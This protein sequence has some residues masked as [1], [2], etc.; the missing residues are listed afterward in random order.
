MSIIQPTLTELAQRADFKNLEDRWLAALEENGAHREDMLNALG[1]LTKDGRTERATALGWTWMESAKERLE[2][3]ELLALGRELILQCG[4]NED[5]RQEILR[6]YGEVFADRP[7]LDRLIEASGLRGGKSPRRALRTLEICLGL[8]VGSHLIS[9]IDE[10][11]AEV[12]AIDSEGPEY[13][14]R[15]KGGRT[16]TLDPDSL[17]LNYDPIEA[18]DF[19]VLIQLHPQ[20]LTNMLESDPAGVV[21]GILQ[22]HRGRLD[23]DELEHLLSPRFVPAARWKDWWSKTRAALKRCPNVIVEGRNPVI[24]TYTATAQTLESEIEPQWQRAETPSQRLATIE[25]YVREAKARGTQLQSSLI[26]RMYRDL[27]A[28]VKATRPGAPSEA[29]TEAI[30]IERLIEVSGL[31]GMESPASAILAE[32]KDVVSLIRGM[33][34][35]KLAL[36]AIELIRTTLPEKWQEIYLDLLPFASIDG[37]EFIS[38][39]LSEAGLS[40]R[41]AEVVARIPT[42]FHDHLDAVCWLWRGPSLEIPEPMPPRELLTRLLNFLN[43]LSRD[44]HAD[45]DFVREAKTRIRSAL[46]AA[47]Y[48]RYSEVIA[49]MEPGLAST[50][51]RTVDRMDALGHVV[52]ADLLKIIREVHP[53]LYAKAKVDPWLDETIIYGT[54]AGMNRREEELNYLLNVKMVEN[55]KAIGEAASHGDLSEN[56]EYK[57]A[58]EERDLLRARAASIQ[59][60]LSRARLLTPNDVSTDAVN[61]GTR[62]ELVGPEGQRRELTILGPWEADVEK[63]IYN[64]KAPLSQKLKGL[65]P[66]DTVTLDLDGTERP[67]R[68]ET[69]TNALE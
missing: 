14:I 43:E 65:R 10:H 33:R 34:E 64:Y 35:P 4:D 60:E 61:I 57:F 16:E 25:T 26:Q 63:G 36:R 20:K 66:G 62:V 58:L 67:Y 55:A 19:R 59:N 51:R 17:A 69:I 18:N 53:Q 15:K 22:S 39:A 8:K 48:A 11:I 52:R 44:D 5:M 46:S 49:G 50:V 45:P 41:L 3:P 12:V 2:P 6:L 47:N 32:S 40:E 21:M 9:R 30:I 42:N 28:R 29:L 13:T 7:E 38:R 1:V 27:Q 68:I 24:L 56:S 23:S 37:C 54:Q 31:A